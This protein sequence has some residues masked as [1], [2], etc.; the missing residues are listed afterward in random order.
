MRLSLFEFEDQPWFPDVLRDYQTGFIAYTARIGG[1]YASLKTLPE[2]A[3]AHQVT[4]LASGA[5]LPAIE[6]T[7]TSRRKGGTL[8]LTDKFPNKVFAA[9]AGRFEGVRY[10]TRSVDVML[11]PLPQGEIYTLFNA[12]HHFNAD[13][14]AAILRKISS[15]GAR[16]LVAEPLQPDFTTFL[17]VALATLIGPFLLTPFIRPFDFRR[18][19]LTYLIPLGVFVTFW[20]GAVSVIR[21][22]SRKEC[23]ALKISLA[24]EG[25]EVEYGTLPSRSGPVTYLRTR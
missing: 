6:A 13:E 19:V 4:D 14:K 10:E 25:I 20:D 21:A 7:E 24:R 12:F 15:Q 23:E 8:L 22:V 1:L 16:A 11:H 2:F 3:E 17:K 18:I 9:E 5:G